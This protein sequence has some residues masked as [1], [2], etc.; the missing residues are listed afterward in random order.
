MIVKKLIEELQ[1]MPLQ[2]EV[3]L[4]HF[5]GESALFVLRK[6]AWGSGSG[7]GWGSGSGRFSTL[8]GHSFFRPNHTSTDAAATSAKC[9]RAYMRCV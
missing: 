9:H 3:K 4:H 2:A 1:S 7:S 8:S 6:K 5:T